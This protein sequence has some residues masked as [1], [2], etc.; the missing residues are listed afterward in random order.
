M[1]RLRALSSFVTAISIIDIIIRI[2][3]LAIISVIIYNVKNCHKFIIPNQAIKC[4]KSNLA[5][6]HQ[7]LQRCVAGADHINIILYETIDE[8]SIDTENVYKSIANTS[9]I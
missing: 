7:Q 4:V 6:E 1:Y 8:R 9:Y 2:Q 3:K 5:T